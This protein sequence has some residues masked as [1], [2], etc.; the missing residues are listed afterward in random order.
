MLAQLAGAR[1]V[2]DPPAAGTASSPRRRSRDASTLT[3]FTSLDE[4]QGAA[5]EV[6][7]SAQRLLSIYTPDLEP[8]LYDTSA[9][10]EIAKRFV[11]SRSF[12]KIRVL[13][14]Q[15]TRLMRESNRFIAMG[16]RL[17]G[18]IDLRY[19]EGTS[20]RASAYV[21]ADDRAIAYRLRADCW[22]GIVDSDNPPVA[23]LHL[24]EFDTIWAASEP[25]F[26]LRVARRA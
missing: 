21:I 12:A 15:P 3:V 17:S 14:W 24:T 5:N 23:R 26:N 10:L 7:S 16:R 4:A 20:Q 13:I 18:S 25:G 2:S 11:L 1:Y 22:D 19:A 9:F 8:E 6:A